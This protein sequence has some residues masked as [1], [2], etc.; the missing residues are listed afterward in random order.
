MKLVVAEDETAALR[1]ELGRWPA[2]LS[3]SLARVETLRAARGVSAAATHSAY[4]L[5][6]DL[7]LLP[8]DEHVLQAAVDAGPV[9]LRSLDA[10]HLAS[11]L[12]L[13][14][15]LGVLITYDQRMAEAATAAGVQT[16]AP[17]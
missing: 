13:G 2:W 7:Q 16:L 17:A 6:E 5:M 14:D 3:S 8:L 11:A 12:S 9:A 15:E 4:R 1:L 10:L